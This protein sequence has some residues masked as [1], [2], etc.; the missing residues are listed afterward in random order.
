MLKQKKTYY[1]VYSSVLKDFWF[2]NPKDLA[3]NITAWVNRAGRLIISR[4][5]MTEEQFNNLKELW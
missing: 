1:R 5:E 2:C 3:E 4:V